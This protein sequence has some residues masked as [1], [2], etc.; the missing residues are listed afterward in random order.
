VS[1][2]KFLCSS[3]ALVEGEFVELKTEINDQSVFLIGT[4]QQGQACVWINVCPHQGRPLNWAPDQ[5][6]KD[7]DGNLVCAAHGAV[8]N[9]QSG[10]CISG[11]CLRSALAAIATEED[12]QSVNFTPP[13]NQA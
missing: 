10:E 4:R 2:S 1:S 13:Q 11:P 9:P 5:F 7:P 3:E 8:F 12:G 6:L